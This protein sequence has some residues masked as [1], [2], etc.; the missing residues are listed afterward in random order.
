ML[1]KNLIVQKNLGKYLFVFASKM[2]LL[3][4]NIDFCP[5]TFSLW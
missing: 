4:I 5:K 2:F 1:K 3:S